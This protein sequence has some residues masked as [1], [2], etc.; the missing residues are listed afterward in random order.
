LA[1]KKI[2]AAA[3]SQ[4]LTFKL[5]LPDDLAQF[6]L[7]AGVQIRLQELLDRQDQGQQ[8]TMAERAEAA[9]P[10]DL[11]ETLTLLR[12]RAERAGLSKAADK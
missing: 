5:E 2:G 6:H 3:V 9:G 8:L 12:L 4:T 11:S 7:P 10:V 1:R